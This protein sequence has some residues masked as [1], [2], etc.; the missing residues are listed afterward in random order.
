MF[1]SAIFKKLIK[2]LDYLYKAGKEIL[3]MY[4][5]IN[6]QLKMAEYKCKP[7]LKKALKKYIYTLSWST[8]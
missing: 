6:Y 5:F 2:I 3:Q 7:H 4:I 1:I 8:A